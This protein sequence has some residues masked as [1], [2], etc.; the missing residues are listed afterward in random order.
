MCVYDSSLLVHTSDQRDSSRATS[1]K[2]RPATPPTIKVVRA[3]VGFDLE[4]S[5]N[6]S[7]PSAVLLRHSNLEDRYLGIPKDLLSTLADL[8]FENVYN[9]HL[10]LHKRSFQQCLTLGTAKP[11]V[12][13]S[14]C[15]FGAR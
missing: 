3:S 12:V 8:Y 7:S 1:R 6:D 15:A 14:V 2:K 4:G 5:A 10:L 11:H 13:L 9:A